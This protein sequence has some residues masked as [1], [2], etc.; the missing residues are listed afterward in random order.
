MEYVQMTLD[1]WVSM[2][3]QLKKDLVGVQESFVRI[4]Y[5]LRRIKEEK[6]YEQ[7]GYTNIA[8]FA[9]AEYGLGASTVSRFIS[10][11]KK[12]SIDGYS[13]RLRPEFANLG[14]SK[15]S[16]ML[17]LPDQDMEMIQAEATK[18]DIRSLKHFN[19][20]EPESGIADDV[21][22][23]IEQFFHEHPDMLNELFNELA[24][25]QEE[26]KKLIEIINP[27]GNR[28]FKKGLYF[29]MM[30]ENKIVIKKFGGTPQEMTWEE[31]I[32]IT[33]EVF[34]EA[35]GP[36]T[37][38][39]YF[40]EEPRKVAPAQ[41]TAENLERS[42]ISSVG[43]EEKKPIETVKKETEELKKPP[44]VT[45][46][47]PKAEKPEEKMPEK[48][49]PEVAE[50]AEILEKPFG[51]RKEYI[52]SLTAHGAAGYL[53]E[54]KYTLTNLL[55]YQEGLKRWLEDKVDADGEKIEETMEG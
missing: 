16:E 14:S 47:S 53:A 54:R 21:R 22:G 50:T 12:Y 18:A 29:L 6:L 9:K 2:K 31:F 37:W 52:D 11:N 49:V 23:L 42:D 1:D 34:E 46:E 33:R 48:D 7:D 51:S 40:K 19:E 8:E 55:D 28:S 3:E 38:Q 13:D 39:N 27:G 45:K 5:T 30:Y 43:K 15:L 10:I 44:V 4:G 20:Q 17:T 24:A 41:E 25:G 32:A 35:A 26:V 36:D